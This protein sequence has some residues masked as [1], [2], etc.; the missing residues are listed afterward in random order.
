MNIGILVPLCSRN[1]NWTEIIHIDFFKFVLP[2]FYRTISN[3][4]NYRFYLAI[5]EN[6]EFL[7]K[8]I[9]LIKM[10][11]HSNDKIFIMDKKLNGNPYAIWSNLLKE[12]MKD[13]NKYF[14]QLGSDIVHVT[15]NW[16]DY[17]IKILKKNDN[18]GITGGV[19]KSFWLERVNKYQNGILENVFFHRSHYEI[20]NNFMNPK[21]KSW[22][23]DDFISQLYRE[24]NR[25]FICPNFLYCNAN[26]VGGHN[27]N[28]RYEPSTEME[29]IW[30]S[31]A[32]KES[33]KIIL[34]I[35]LKK[36]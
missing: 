27:E 24:V 28:N 5:D 35:K 31:E 18:I 11:L 21:F 19:D 25:C 15:K 30:K 9:D 7:M 16:D 2:S 23:G 3:K 6:D 17:Y 8:N 13:E 1:Q 36:K 32:L 20:F 29:S 12:A 34:Y 4:H 14:Y 22:F 10:R 26:R 33:K